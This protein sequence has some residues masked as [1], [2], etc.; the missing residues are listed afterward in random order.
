MSWL[1]RFAVFWYDFIV[2]DSAVLAIGAV[3]A[4]AVTAGLIRAG[5][6][7]MAPALL[8]VLV[9]ITLAISLRSPR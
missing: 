3:A 9:A 1:G 7:A 5:M 2:G 8:P 4:L 6:A